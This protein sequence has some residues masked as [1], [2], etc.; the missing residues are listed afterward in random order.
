MVTY[1]V[2][3]D[4]PYVIRSPELTADHVERLGTQAAYARVWTGKLCSN[5]VTFQVRGKRRLGIF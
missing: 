3:D 5:I 2:D 4:Y 1:Q